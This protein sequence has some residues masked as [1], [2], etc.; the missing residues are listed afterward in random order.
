[1]LVFVYAKNAVAIANGSSSTTKDRHIRT[2]AHPHIRS[3]GLNP[4]L[5][6]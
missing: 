3:V 6:D 4:D 1:M 2:S 5:A